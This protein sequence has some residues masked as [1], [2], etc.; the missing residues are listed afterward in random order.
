MPI[1]RQGVEYRGS[2]RPRALPAGK[3]CTVTGERSKDVLSTWPIPLLVASGVL[4]VSVG[5]FM[6]VTRES[7]H[8]LIFAIAVT[9]ANGGVVVLGRWRLRRSRAGPPRT[10][11]TLVP[12]ASSPA[13]LSAATRWVGGANLP[14]T[15]GR[16]NAT[17][18]LAV[19]RLGSSSISLD[20]RPKLV[21]RM[22]GLS[23]ITVTRSDNVVVFPV[24]SRFGT[25]GVGVGQ[26]GVA[27]LYFWTTKRE[28][29]LQ[30]LASADW[31]VS[32]DER[33]FTL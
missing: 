20:V 13:G 22:V 27:P 30:A 21:A 31:S 10:G 3:L 16:T 14:G 5:A 1:S 17:T 18:P 12:P 19:L 25:R 23:P 2:A 9:M 7:P 28:E 15:L 24:R 26:K 8:F 33:R 29:V 11:R 32:W 6:A 4:A